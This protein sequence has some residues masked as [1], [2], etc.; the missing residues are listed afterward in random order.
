MQREL[1]RPELVDLAPR[2]FVAALRKRKKATPRPSVARIEHLQR[3]VEALVESIAGGALCASLAIAHRLAGADAELLRLQERPQDEP[4]SD[5]TVFK[6]SAIADCYLAA[7][8]R[9]ARDAGQS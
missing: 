2:R 7:V 9:F 1:L 6:T 4:S 3:K 5:A 8:P